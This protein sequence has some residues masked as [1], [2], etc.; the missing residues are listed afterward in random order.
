VDKEGNKVGKTT[1]NALFL[2]STPEN[3]YAG[4]MSFPDE[5]IALGFE[6]LTEVDL[7]GIDEKIKTDPMGEKK[8]LAFEIVKML[9]GNTQADKAQKE[10]E[11]T[12][13]KRGAPSQMQT[14]ISKQNL[15]PLLD[16]VF[17]TKAVT[18]RSEAKRLIYEKAIEVGGRK[19]T[20]PSEE[21]QISSSGVIIRIGK[22]KFIKVKSK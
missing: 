11:Q 16:L 7:S 15:L 14:V 9:W 3:Y 1:G 18:S 2:D 21:I 20:D 10:F 6:L 8:R 5:T 22:K 4:I 19:Y 12:F 13:Q 17:L